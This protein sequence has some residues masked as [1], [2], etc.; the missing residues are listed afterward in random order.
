M[1]SGSHAA[2]DPRVGYPCRKKFKIMK[3]IYSGKKNLDITL[4]SQLIIIYL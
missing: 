1:S 4:T 2:R 3:T